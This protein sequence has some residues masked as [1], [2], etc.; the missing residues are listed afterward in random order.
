MNLINVVLFGNSV[1]TVDAFVP[2]LESFLQVR[3]WTHV[4]IAGPMKFE[5]RFSKT[6]LNVHTPPLWAGLFLLFLLFCLERGL[7]FF[8]FFMPSRNPTI[9]LTFCLG[10]NLPTR[11]GVQPLQC[12]GPFAFA[13]AFSPRTGFRSFFSR[14]LRLSR[15]LPNVS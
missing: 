15:R 13:F 6:F 10:P 14:V 3:A 1:Q 11:T 4:L 12:Q 2:S 8:F 7:L 5:A 9:V